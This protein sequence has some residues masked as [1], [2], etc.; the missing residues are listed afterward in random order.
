MP[1]AT[2][3]ATS[4][5]TL[6][7][8]EPGDA[9]QLRESILS[10]LEELKLVFPWAQREPLA[11]KDAAERLNAMREDFRA[12][13]R[14]AYG[15]FDLGE[16][17]VLGGLDL[18]PGRRPG[19]RELSYWIRTSRTRRGYA[20]EAVSAVTTRLFA[21]PDIER[22][23]IR[24]QRSNSR[25]AAIPERLG[26]CLRCED[27]RKLDDGPGD[28]MIWELTRDRFCAVA[29]LPARPRPWLN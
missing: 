28:A 5:L 10:S 24:C 20:T 25:G 12:G 15:I 11:L 7:C 17:M 18:R 13:R 3:I 19:D 23:L 27:D 4:R 1:V 9:G 8:W 21:D 29:R 6:R 22:V 26:Y 14:W 2:S 16:T